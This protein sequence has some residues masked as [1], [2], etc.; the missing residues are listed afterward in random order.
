VI[1]ANEQGG[2]VI[3]DT[4]VL[5]GGGAMLVAGNKIG[6]DVAGD[7]PRLVMGNRR[8][9]VA[10]LDASGVTVTSN[11]VA[12]NI[13][14]GICGSRS[15]EIELSNNEVFANLKGDTVDTCSD[16]AGKT[17]IAGQR[18]AGEGSGIALAATDAHVTGNTLSGN[19]GDALTLEQGSTAIITGN[20]ID[21]NTGLGLNN[22][23]PAA[24]VMAQANWWGD[25]SGPGGTSSGAGDAV[26]DGVDFSGWLSAMVAVVISAAHEEG[27]LPI[28]EADTLSFFLQNW[29]RRLSLDSA[30]FRKMGTK[31]PQR[32]ERQLNCI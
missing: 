20:N 8:Y 30:V 11:R 1:A 12:Y 10:L 24:I 28:G 3:K 26:S 21:G 6:T 5:G 27:V 9:G 23:D 15:R 2:V 16:E 22:L 4:P 18:L 29:Q 19:E 17:G 13:G 7:D 25:A 31:C 32:S 14:R